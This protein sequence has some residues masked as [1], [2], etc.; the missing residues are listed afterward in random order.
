MINAG[1]WVARNVAIRSIPSACRF[2]SQ[3]HNQDNAHLHQPSSSSAVRHAVADLGSGIKSKFSAM[4]K[5]TEDAAAA[6]VERSERVALRVQERDNWPTWHRHNFKAILQIFAHH[7][8]DLSGFLKLPDQRKLDRDFPLV[9]VDFEKLRN[10]P[11]IAGKV[12]CTWLGHATIL[13]QLDG[14]NILCDPVFSKRSSAWQTVGP[15]RFRRP[16]CT[17]DDFVK[18]NIQIDL[19]LISHNHYDHLDYTSVRKIASEFDAKWIV[20]LKLGDW[21]ST[22][23]PTAIKRGLVELDWHESVELGGH[24]ITA[25]PA[26]HWSCRLPWDRDQSLW[27]GF[28]VV[29]KLGSKF[30]FVGDTA[31]FDGVHGIGEKYGPFDLAAVPI[32]AYSPRELFNHHHID[33]SEAVEVVKAV[34]AD[35]AVPIHWGTFRLASEPPLEPRDLLLQ[36]TNAANFPEF[37]FRPWRIGETE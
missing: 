1:E 3:L 20:P 29:G 36:A 14:L 22:Y 33:P 9:P 34:R 18:E 12:Q 19:V 5:K 28:S 21:F 23:C 27:C 16:A 25:T 2:S 11:S 17:I 26:Q 13:V 24:V 8:S 31:W 32:G 4:K 10:P 15:V 7:L 30:L 35:K 37:K 6:S